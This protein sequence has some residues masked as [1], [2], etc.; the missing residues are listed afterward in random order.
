MDA[1]MATKSPVPSDHPF[2][3]VLQQLRQRG[4]GVRLF[5]SDRARATCPSHRDAR[6]SLG[7]TR[8]D[9]KVLLHCFAGC[10]Q[11]KVVHALGLRMADL[12]TRSTVHAAPRLIAAEYDYVDCD[13]VLIAQKVRYEPKAFN[14]RHVDVSMPSGYIAGGS[15]GRNRACT[16]F[17][18]LSVKIGCTALKAKRQ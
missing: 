12:F 9:S 7:I 2:E 6:P 18:T 15:M 10:S 8:R 5:G 13:G 1:G 14:W 3:L 11:H 4:C 16:T 17:R